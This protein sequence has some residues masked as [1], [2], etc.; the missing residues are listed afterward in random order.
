MKCKEIQDIILTD[1]LDN[2]LSAEHQLMIEA[3][4][5]QCPDCQIIAQDA[6]NL[7]S[8]F[9]DAKGIKLDEDKI[10]LKV[11]AR[12]KEDSATS[13]VYTPAVV[14]HSIIERFIRQRRPSFALATLAGLIL[15]V[16]LL[17]IPTRQEIVQIEPSEN[18][19]YLAYVAEELTFEDEV[20][21]GLHEDFGTAIEEFFL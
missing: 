8:T 20:I 17:F 3:H 13:T 7:G 16:L 18:I 11:E 2:E 14:Q 12:I 4:L 10:W 19:Q 1:Y 21:E 5:R 6:R 15:M 9:L